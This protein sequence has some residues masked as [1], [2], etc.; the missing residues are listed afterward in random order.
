VGRFLRITAITLI[1][2][3][4][5][6]GQP[7][8]AADLKLTAGTNLHLTAGTYNFNSILLQGGAQLVVDSGPIIMNITGT[9]QTNPVD[10]AGG[11]VSN[12]SYIPKLF[13]ILY[14][15]TA[16][17]Q[18]SGGA[19]TALMVFAPNAAVNLTGG[20]NIYGAVLGKTIADNGG[21][22]VHYDRDLPSEFAM[23]WNTM[24]SSF[25]WKK[26]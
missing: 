22:A 25:T 12:P 24:L 17:V 1:L 15:G 13:Q 5:P 19:S 14:G 7:L 6:L 18:I 21:T 10:F 11:T 3:L 20:S 23:A 9:G 4:N 16:G 26:N 8:Y 2:V